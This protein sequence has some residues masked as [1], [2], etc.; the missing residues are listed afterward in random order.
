MEPDLHTRLDLVVAGL[1]RTFGDRLVAVVAYGRPSREWSHSLALVTSLTM[2]DLTG[3]AAAA[4][5]WHRAGAA[6]PLVIP[7]DEF[8]RSLD[9]FPIEYGDII[10]AHTVLVGDDPFAAVRI[11]RLDFRRAVEVQAA[12]HL[13]HLRED[14]IETGGRPTAVGTLVH[15]SAPGFAQLLR[16][17]AHLDDAPAD[18]AAALSHWAATRAGL[19]ARI[20]GDVLALAGEGVPA[21]DAARLFPDYLFTVSALRQFVDQWSTD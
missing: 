15:D 9:A 4:P 11:D 1:R 6:T 21:V 10:D 2:D 20:V 18:S 7:R 5:G 17:M 14:Y 13:L 16:R 19:D 12:S 3:L 8:A